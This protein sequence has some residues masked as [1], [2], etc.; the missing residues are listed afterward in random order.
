MVVTQGFH[1]LNTNGLLRVCLLSQ[2]RRSWVW[3]MNTEWSPDIP[4]GTS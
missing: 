4:F 2:L 1:F 3:G